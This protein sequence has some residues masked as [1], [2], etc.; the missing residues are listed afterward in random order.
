MEKIQL[1]NGIGYA[2]T[3]GEAVQKVKEIGATI[4]SEFSIRL[5]SDNPFRN[6]FSYSFYTDKR[7]EFGQEEIAHYSVSMGILVILT[8]WDST[9]IEARE[10][11]FTKFSGIL[12]INQFWIRK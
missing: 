6:P 7:S 12:S 4:F 3:L 8:R 11:P 1:S 9:H 2:C 10:E 5:F